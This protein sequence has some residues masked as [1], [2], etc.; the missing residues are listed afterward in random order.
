MINQ[1]GNI[2]EGV[3]TLNE[4][5]ASLDGPAVH[6]SNND[7][8]ERFRKRQDHTWMGLDNEV[9][10]RD[11]PAVDA[12]KRLVRDGWRK[13]VDLMAEI[14]DKITAPTP[15]SSGSPCRRLRNRPVVITS[16]R[17]AL[18]V[19]WSKRTL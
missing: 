3:Y 11:E 10:N 9:L 16:S 14:A 8:L 6:G 1:N 13:G 7:E 15:I 2:T 19:R 12:A 4:F 17:V 5:L 18:E